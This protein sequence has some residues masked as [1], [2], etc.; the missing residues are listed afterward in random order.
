MI[1]HAHTFRNICRNGK[2][3]EQAKQVIPLHILLFH[4]ARPA[5][6]SLGQYSGLP[7]FDEPR[8]DPPY[9]LKSTISSTRAWR[10]LTKRE[11]Y[12]EIWLGRVGTYDRAKYRK[13]NLNWVYEFECIDGHERAKG[14]V[15]RILSLIC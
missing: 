4:H 14:Q 3:D 1:T 11:L 6:T 13:Q 15:N 7:L 9:F 8:S 2:L 12:R 10:W 5:C